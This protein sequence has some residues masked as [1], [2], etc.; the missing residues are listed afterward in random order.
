M[1]I[2]NVNF[3]DV[4]CV[5]GLEFRKKIAS[6]Q[7]VLVVVDYCV[8]PFIT[9][10]FYPPRNSVWRMYPSMT[11]CRG[12]D[13]DGN[14]EYAEWMVNEEIGMAGGKAPVSGVLNLADFFEKS[15]PVD[16]IG[17]WGFRFN[18][19]A[20]S[21]EKICGY[22]ENWWNSLGDECLIKV[23]DD[24][25]WQRLWWEG[26][27]SFVQKDDACHFMLHLWELS[28]ISFAR[29]SAFADSENSMD[30]LFLKVEKSIVPAVEVVSG[31]PGKVMREMIIRNGMPDKRMK[32]VPN[33]DFKSELKKRDMLYYKQCVLVRRLNRVSM[34][35]CVKNAVSDFEKSLM[36]FD[37]TYKEN[38][39]EE[40][41]S[42]L[43]AVVNKFPILAV[44][45]L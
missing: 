38:P 44:E 41:K 14:D 33:L 24:S 10:M 20:E 30:E 26:W 45:N 27:W 12:E 25:T 36:L 22:L 5:N 29:V 8:I 17:P 35:G 21:F 31:M 3:S 42:Y 34:Y 13:L 40:L 18:A 39:M 15:S 6:E 4:A 2:V 11:V 16:S 32:P 7:A 19:R 1:K 23:N 43:E 28:D 9:L 37:Y